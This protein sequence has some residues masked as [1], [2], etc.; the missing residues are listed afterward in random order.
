M[1]KLS[2]QLG[3]V[4]IKLHSPDRPLSSLLSD[5][6][7]QIK[8]VASGTG[9]ASHCAVSYFFRKEKSSLTSEDAAE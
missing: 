8:A 2:K 4:N 9:A 6:S 3:E 1:I 7:F 5:V